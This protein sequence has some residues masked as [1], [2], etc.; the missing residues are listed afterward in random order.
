MTNFYAYNTET[1]DSGDDHV[2]KECQLHQFTSKKD[3]DVWVSSRINAKAV[4]VSEIP[5]YRMALFTQF[6]KTRREDGGFWGVVD[7]G[8]N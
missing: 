4:K 7:S 8:T 2:Y 5:A 1:V 3:R 6:G